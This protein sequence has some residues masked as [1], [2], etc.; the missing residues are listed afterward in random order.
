MHEAFVLELLESGVHRA[1]AGSPGT[2]APAFE[3]LDDLIA[4]RRFLGQEDE[5]RCAH[6]TACRSPA[7]A[8]LGA[9]ASWTAEPG[10]EVGCVEGRPATPVATTGTVPEVLA[11]GC[12]VMPHGHLVVRGVVEVF[13]GHVGSL[14]SG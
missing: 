11:E 14:Q 2:L 6:V 7:G 3:L 12:G 4:V 8:E 1:R 10:S 5:D 13:S 9:E